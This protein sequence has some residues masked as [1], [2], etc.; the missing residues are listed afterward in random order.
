[1]NPPSY[2]ENALSTWGVT[3][4]HLYTTL[5]EHHVQK[6]ITLQLNEIKIF[7]KVYMTIFTVTQP[8]SAT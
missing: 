5:V 6:L 2:K 8:Y 3:H 1:M 4:R 7:N